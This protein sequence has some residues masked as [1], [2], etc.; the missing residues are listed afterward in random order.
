MQTGRKDSDKYFQA[1]MKKAPHG[2][3]FISNACQK[4]SGHLKHYKRSVTQAWTL[5]IAA[6]K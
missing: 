6:F 2:A 1:P 3:F 5:A 4:L